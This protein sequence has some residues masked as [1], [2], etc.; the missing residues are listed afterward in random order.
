MTRS[1]N[2]SKGNR[3]LGATPG[4]ARDELD[5]GG[6]PKDALGNEGNARKQRRDNCQA[7]DVRNGVGRT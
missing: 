7:V 3:Y 6:T 5:S 2:K 1:E 4:S